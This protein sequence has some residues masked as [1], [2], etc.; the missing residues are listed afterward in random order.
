MNSATKYMYHVLST[1]YTMFM[2]LFSASTIHQYH[3]SSRY[4]KVFIVCIFNPILIDVNVFPRLR[5]VNNFGTWGILDRLHGTD[6]LFRQSKQYQNHRILLGLTPARELA[7][8]SKD[9]N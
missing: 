8:D 6:A 1:Q 4:R 2:D 3:F 9:V 7:N 5:F